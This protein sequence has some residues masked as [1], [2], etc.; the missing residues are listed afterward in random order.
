MR[1][2]REGG[3]WNLE[4]LRMA[5]ELAVDIDRMTKTLPKHEMY[6][7]GRQ[8]RRA[9][10]SICANIVEG[11]GRRQYKGEYVKF[12]VYAL[13]SCDE[14]KLHLDLLHD[15]GSLERERYEELRQRCEGV[16]IKLSRFLEG[17]IQSHRTA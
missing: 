9:V 8:I 13:S 7:E 17:V 6:E 4:V 14:T 16:G 2:R 12:L 11:Y 10:K 5:Y 1:E 3:Y 15:C